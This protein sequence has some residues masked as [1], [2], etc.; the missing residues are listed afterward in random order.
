MDID[1]TE[2]YLNGNDLVTSGGNNVIVSGS[3]ALE[4]TATNGLIA[5][6]ATITDLTATNPITGS[7][8]GTAAN[9]TG[10][11]AIANGGTGQTSQ[12]AAIDAL[13]GAVTDAQFLRGDGTNV[14]MSAIQVSDVPTLNQTTTGNAATATTSTNIA[15]GVIGSVPYQ[16]GAGA[17]QML[18]A[19]AEGRVLTSHAAAAPTWETPS[20]G[21][22]DLTTEVSN[23]LP[24]GNG[25]TGQTTYADGELLIGNSSNTLTK[26]NLTAGSGIDITNGDGSITVSNNIAVNQATGTGN[27]TTI[28]PA[29]IIATGMNITPGPGDYLVFFT[30]SSSN[31]ANNQ[32]N[33]FSI[34]SNNIQILASEITHTTVLNDANPVSAIAY[35]AGLGAGQVIDVRWKTTGGIATMVGGRTLILQKVK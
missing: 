1:L 3:E 24:I 5:N 19:G 8:T 33:N 9:V 23:T 30:C 15:G 22:V 27:I 2:A 20:F 6:A 35:V 18:A 12:Q 34:F 16:T 13:A 7:V 4:I 32:T 29:Y 14:S 21:N 26:A 10:T 11:V 25:G 31:S 28:S 17:T